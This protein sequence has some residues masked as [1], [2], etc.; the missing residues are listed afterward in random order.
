MLRAFGVSDKGPVRPVNEDCFAIDES[1][2]LLVVADGMGG[3]RAGEIAA[4]L[5]VDAICTVFAAPREADLWPFGFDAAT[6]STGNLLRTAVHTANLRIL[7]RAG[8]DNEYAGR[9]TTVVAAA[10]VGDRLSVAHVGDSRLYL[11]AGGAL[12]HVTR[13]DSWMAAV[14]AQDP[15]VDPAAFRHHPLRYALTNVVGRQSPPV[16]HIFETILPGESWL[17]LTTDGVHGTLSDGRIEQ[18]FGHGN[19]EDIA[20]R[21]VRE[22]LAQGSRD[23]CTAVAA[24]YQPGP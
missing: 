9:G 23:N 17:A 13:D 19:P 21:L 4:R 18:V 6:S 24:G 22:A 11:F 10:V 8:S 2:H 20:T 12:Q 1:H 14:L 5:A 15:G 7:E 16:V 3:H